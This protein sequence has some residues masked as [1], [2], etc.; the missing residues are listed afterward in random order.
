MRQGLKMSIASVFSIWNAPFWNINT[1]A[2]R[3][4][5]NLCAKAHVEENW[6][7]W[8]A[9]PPGVPAGSR[10]LL[11][12]V[13]KDILDCSAISILQLTPHKAKELPSQPKEIWKIINC[14]CF[15]PL[16]EINIL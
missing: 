5:K 2:V 8:P 13:G 12:P 6:S 10:H 16:F 7:F 11:Q 4:S 3:K 15:K 14:C 1:D 9:G